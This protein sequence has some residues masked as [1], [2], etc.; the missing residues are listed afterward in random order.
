MKHRLN[1]VKS[2]LSAVLFLFAAGAASTAFAQGTQTLRFTADADGANT[3]SA[4]A[5]AQSEF[6]VDVYYDDDVSSGGVSVVSFNVHFNNT[7]LEFKEVTDLKAIADADKDACQDSGSQQPAAVG[8]NSANLKIGGPALAGASIVSPAADS[9]DT[10]NEATTDMAIQLSWA[11]ICGRVF[12]DGGNGT[13]V[14]VATV[15]FARRT[16]AADGSITKLGL[17]Q[18]NGGD[19]LASTFSGTG[20]SIDVQSFTLDVDGARG[21]A[22]SDILMIARYFAGDRGATITEGLSA[23]LAATVQAAIEAGA[24]GPLDVDGARGFATSDILMIARYFAGDRGAAITEGLS[25]T[26][27]DTVQANIEA[28]L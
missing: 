22:T 18:A 2:A 3:F 23:T 4:G 20:A 26:D 11:Q 17:S 28:L 7:D 15:K 6:T 14:K 12:A 9:S 8:T 13:P 10:D 25:A 27:P 19:Y 5:D 16:A 1:L 24:S 21:F